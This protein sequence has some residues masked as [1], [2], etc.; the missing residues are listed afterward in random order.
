MIASL[1]S[2]RRVLASGAAILAVV[3]LGAAALLVGPGA[4]APASTAAASP[5]T[6]A[7]PTAAGTSFASIGS[8]ALVTPGSTASPSRDPTFPPI[9]LFATQPPQLLHPSEPPGDSIFHFDAGR[10]IAAQSTDWLTLKAAGRIVLSDGKI[11]VLA[12]GANPLVN[13]V[14]GNPV[15]DARR[16]DVTWTRWVVEPPASGTDAKGNRYY[17]LSYWN[18]CGPGATA[19]ALYYWQQLTGHPNVTGTAGYA[20]DP[21]VATGVAWPS[22]GPTFAAPNGSAEHLGTYW[23]GSVNVNG[24]TAHGRGYLM[25]LAMAVR[26][27]G[28]TSPGIDIFVDGRGKALYPT[29]GSPTRDI[30]AALNWEASSHATDWTETYYTTVQRWD[31]N[32]ARDLQVAVMLDVGRDGVPV[33]AAADTFDLPNWQ[34]GSNTPHTRHAIAI[35]GYDNTANPPTFTYLDTCGRSCN[36]RAGNQNGQIHVISQAQMVKALTDGNGMG[37]I[38]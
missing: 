38:W 25:Y 14:T 11:G 21:Y 16:L 4:G 37:F 5:A 7:M 29:E 23:S 20:L 9:D 6:A 30:Q 22:R 36:S 28:W 26:P 10:P 34:A 8:S 2:R 33:V 19:I 17:D 32:L 1:R 3:A 35:V 12:A 13:P 27:A 31:P 18:M 24:F 15:P